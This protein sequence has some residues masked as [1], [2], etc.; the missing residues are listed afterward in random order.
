MQFL[1]MFPL[2]IFV[3][4]PMLLFYLQSMGFTPAEV[5]AYIQA[6]LQN[7]GVTKAELEADIENFLKSNM[8]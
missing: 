7:T 2:P 5:E 1:F 3:V 8:S 4:P 6:F